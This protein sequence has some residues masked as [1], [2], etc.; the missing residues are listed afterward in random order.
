MDYQIVQV[1]KEQ[2]KEVLRNHAPTDYVQF[3]RGPAPATNL[4][5]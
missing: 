2:V 5:A 4:K 3:S 1:N